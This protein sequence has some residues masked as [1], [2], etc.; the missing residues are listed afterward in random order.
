[1]NVTSRFLVHQLVARHAAIAAV[2]VE[3]EQSFDELWLDPLDV[4]LIVVQLE[5]MDELRREVPIDALEH[6][7]TV[8]A[9]VELV[10]AWRKH[11]DV[12]EAAAPPGSRLAQA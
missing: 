12:P 1:M 7:Q 9:L 5:S 11:K 3:D 6:V 2:L 4:I 10:D 8:G